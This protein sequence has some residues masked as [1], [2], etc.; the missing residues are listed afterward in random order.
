MNK[1]HIGVLLLLWLLATAS[2]AQSGPTSVVEIVGTT[3]LSTDKLLALCRQNGVPTTGVYNWQNHL[4]AYGPT[5]SIR[6]LQQTVKAAYKGATVKLYDAPFYKFDRQRCTDKTTAKQWDNIILTANLVKDEAKQ[7]E[8]LQYHATQFQKWPEVSNG[9]CNASFQQ[10]LIFRQG[11]Q[12]MLIISIPKGADLDEL[13]PRTTQNN[14][15]VDDWNALMKQYQE[16]ITGTKP[17]ETWVFLKPV[18]TVKRAV[19]QKQ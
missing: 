19:S 11:R 9:F 5:A 2:F 16:G 1:P 7:Q 14:P 12:L 8:Y 4:V 18:A 3:P 13:N 15:R 10:L 6:K 17:G